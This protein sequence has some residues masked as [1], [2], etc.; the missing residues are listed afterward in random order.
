MSDCLKTGFLAQRH[1]TPHA[2]RGGMAKAV[3]PSQKMQFKEVAPNQA[4]K[5]RTGS[6]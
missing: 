6:S 3:G 2:C 5:Q 4:A 1:Q